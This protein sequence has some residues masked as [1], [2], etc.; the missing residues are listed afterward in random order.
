MEIETYFSSCPTFRY[1][2]RCYLQ[3]VICAFT[4]QLTSKYCE[5]IYC[6]QIPHCLLTTP[7]VLS[8]A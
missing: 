7:T 3:I 4:Q 5:A 1:A 6:W 8:A 2:G